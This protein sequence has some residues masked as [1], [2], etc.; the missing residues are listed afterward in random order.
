MPDENTTADLTVQGLG[1]FIAEDPD[2]LFDD[3][4]R[5]QVENFEIGTVQTQGDYDEL[6]KRL[7]EDRT[8]FKER[9]AKVY[10]EALT[11]QFEESLKAGGSKSSIR[12]KGQ[13]RI[14]E[15]TEE[16]SEDFQR[17]IDRTKKTASTILDRN[18]QSLKRAFASN[19]QK[20]GYEPA[21]NES[22]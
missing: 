10:A 6:V 8:I 17:N 2:L 7:E 3:L 1:S 18:Q 14:G 16:A 11:G 19:L 4:L 15:K 21:F 9:S 20:S 13:R 22:F 12:L 5:E